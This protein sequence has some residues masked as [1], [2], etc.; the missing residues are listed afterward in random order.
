MRRRYRQLLYQMRHQAGDVDPLEPAIRHFLK[1]TRSYWPGLFVCYSV[2]DLPRTNNDLEHCFGSV[3]Y[4]ERRAS[5]RKLASPML[6][7]RGSVRLVT[8]TTAARVFT[9][10]EL[11][12]RCLADWQRLRRDL[13]QRHDTRR[14]QRHFRRD[15]AAYLAQA[16]AL[17][18]Q[19][20][21]PP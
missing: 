9:A 21:L 2:P 6:L 12:P 14:A 18:L 5:G 13:A 16:E 19:P 20:S 15:P 8:A 10:E 3:R 7:V 11:R 17:L 4:H 1:V